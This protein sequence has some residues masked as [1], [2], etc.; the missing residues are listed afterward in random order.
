VQEHSVRPPA[1]FRRGKETRPNTNGPSCSWIIA[2]LA[3]TPKSPWP[4]RCNANE[5]R[6]TP[7]RPQVLHTT[8]PEPE[9]PHVFRAA[10]IASPAL[11]G[12][13]PSAP[14]KRPHR[15][16]PVGSRR[17]PCR[18]QTTQ[19]RDES[20][21]D[22]RFNHRRPMQTSYQPPPPILDSITVLAE[23]G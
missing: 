8:A 14:G 10:Q 5:T 13:C 3:G 11:E 22:I 4:R 7:S 21:P 12:C 18:H 2:L 6:R 15:D 23:D 19:S 9:T 1:R 17:P 20:P 16:R